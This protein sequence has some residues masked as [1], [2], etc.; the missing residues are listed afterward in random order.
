MLAW[1]NRRVRCGIGERKHT[2]RLFPSHSTKRTPTRKRKILQLPRVV[3]HFNCEP[4][5]SLALMPVYSLCS[6]SVDGTIVRFLFP[7]PRQE[8]RTI[9]RRK[10]RG[11]F[12]HATNVAHL[13]GRPKKRLWRCAKLRWI[14]FR[15]RVRTHSRFIQCVFEFIFHSNLQVRFLARGRIIKIFR[16]QCISLDDKTKTLNDNLLLLLI[17][18]WICIIIICNI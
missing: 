13:N 11:Q 5:A 1:F 15:L 7:I 16:V 3:S 18:W 8:R 6:G 9:S 17:K 4:R 10:K 12:L 2:G 14:L